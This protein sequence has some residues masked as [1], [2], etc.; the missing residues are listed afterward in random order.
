MKR[1]QIQIQFNW[2][3]IAVVGAIILIAG[4][5]IIPKLKKSATDSFNYDVKSYLDLI[6]K[7]I[8]LNPKAESSTELSGVAIKFSCDRYIIDEISSPLSSIVFSPDKITGNLLGTSRYFEHPFKTELF[9]FV[10][11]S[12]I[13]YVLKESG[14]V[15][16]INESLPININKIVVK[17]FKEINNEN[18]DKI[19]YIAIDEMP[20]VSQLGDL[21]GIKDEDVT[22]L[23]VS[24]IDSWFG[25]ELRNRFDGFFLE[26]IEKYSMRIFDFGTIKYYKKTGNSFKEIGEVYFLDEASLLAAIYSENPEMYNCGMLKGFE[27]FKISA[28]IKLDRIDELSRIKHCP[29]MNPATRLNKMIDLTSDIQHTEG[30]YLDI[31]YYGTILSKDNKVLMRLSCP[32]VY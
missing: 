22:F 12:N 2:I 28:E 17:N 8:Q 16:L 21:N 30:F 27:K 5:S 13:K 9:S 18:Y 19:R 7:N 31:Y 4:L 11:G 23:V 24:V 32:L 25:P 1:G 6:L 20:D 26:G 10:T 14:F 3:Y 15:Q 29:Y